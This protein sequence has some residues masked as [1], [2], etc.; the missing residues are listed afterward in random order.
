MYTVAVT[1]TASN[2][3]IAAYSF[4]EGSGTTLV[5]R[6]GRGHTGTVS[7]PTW[8]AGTTG[9]GLRFDGIDDLVT[10]AD[11]RAKH[12]CQHQGS[13]TLDNDRRGHA[14]PRSRGIWASAPGHVHSHLR[15]R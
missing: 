12:R 1:V 11:S 5:D 4:D 7:G 9:G 2:P 15:P 10:I 8:T 13:C 14:I 6:S 3:P